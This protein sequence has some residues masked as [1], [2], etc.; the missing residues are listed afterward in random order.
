M[1]GHLRGGSAHT[2]V[3]GGILG[4]D[5][6]THSCMCCHSEKFQLRNGWHNVTVVCVSHL[7]WHHEFFQIFA[8]GMCPLNNVLKSQSLLQSKEFAYMDSCTQ[9]HC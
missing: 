7:A 2:G 3:C 9:R 4:R 1:W 8:L 5:V 6:L